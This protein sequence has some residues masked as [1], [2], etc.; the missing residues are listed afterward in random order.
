MAKKQ[1]M[2]Y[3]QEELNAMKINALLQGLNPEDIQ[4]EPVEDD[5][6][7][8]IEDE[9]PKKSSK[10]KKEEKP[11]NNGLHLVPNLDE[12]S[13]LNTGLSMNVTFNEHDIPYKEQ[14]WG[15]PSRT[16]VYTLELVKQCKKAKD[17]A[18]D[19]SKNS[20]EEIKKA[21]LGQVRYFRLV[22]HDENILNVIRE[23]AY[24]R[25]ES[26]S[27]KLKT[28]I[29]VNNKLLKENN[30][31]PERVKKNLEKLVLTISK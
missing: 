11:S 17:I 29:F 9:K 7:I 13:K 1:K 15:I 26:I 5:F 24:V 27:G 14:L 18:R 22:C 25:V 2:K 8:E 6:E 30:A 28:K 10:A 19:I 23:I 16:L 31:N 4:N 21:D 20:A 3:T 12:Y